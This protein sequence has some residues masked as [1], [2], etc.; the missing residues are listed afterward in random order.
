MQCALRLAHDVAVSAVR[1]AGAGDAAPAPGVLAAIAAFGAR[2]LAEATG[3][4]LGAAVD[5]E[6]EGLAAL[7]LGAVHD[8]A[9]V[10]LALA[11]VA[12]VA[13]RAAVVAVHHAVGRG[14]ADPPLHRDGLAVLGHH[15]LAVD[16]DA[17][18]DSLGLSLGVSVIR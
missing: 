11:G 13:G 1:V 17:E 7:A 2:P 5:V 6:A 3:I 12:Q 14:Q 15:L 8:A 16:G 18:G 9:A 4:S 10:G